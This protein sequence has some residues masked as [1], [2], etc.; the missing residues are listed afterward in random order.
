M[1]SCGRRVLEVGDIATE[2]AGREEEKHGRGNGCQGFFHGAFLPLLF[3]HKATKA[4]GGSFSSV[5]MA[6]HNGSR[7]SAGPALGDLHA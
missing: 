6:D 2:T 4:Q 7:G 5:P 3:S 1:V